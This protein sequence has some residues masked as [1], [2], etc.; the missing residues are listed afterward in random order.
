MIITDPALL[1]AIESRR[2]ELEAP[3]RGL[4][5][6][7]GECLERVPEGQTFWVIVDGK[8]FLT[9]THRPPH[10]CKDV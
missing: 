10:V 6:Y 7:V 8:K 2:K 3:R 9:C 5:G 1:T 4:G